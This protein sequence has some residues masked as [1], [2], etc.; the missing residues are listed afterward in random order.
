MGPCDG[1]IWE[2]I[3][4]MPRI[5]GDEGIDDKDEEDEE[6]EGEGPMVTVKTSKMEGEVGGVVR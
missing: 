3:E 4:I 2:V 1:H 6:D 5:F